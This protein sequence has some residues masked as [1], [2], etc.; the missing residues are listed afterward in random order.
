[1]VGRDP[2]HETRL[3]S[4]GVVTLDP[5]ERSIGARLG[6]GGVV[7]TEVAVA[8]RYKASAARIVPL[9][10]DHRVGNGPRAFIIRSCCSGV[11]SAKPVSWL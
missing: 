8:G 4:I 7:G 3:W 2:R 5:P 11:S 1:M 10:G 9:L 6:A